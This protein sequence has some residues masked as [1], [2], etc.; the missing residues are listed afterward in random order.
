MKLFFTPQADHQAMEIDSW[1]RE[2]RAGAR[3]LFAR[4][5]AETREL[6]VGAPTAGILFFPCRS[7]CASVA[8][9]PTSALPA[10]FGP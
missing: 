2:H 5:L 10:S 7:S 9:S 4:E 6:I 1:W 8:G 3:D